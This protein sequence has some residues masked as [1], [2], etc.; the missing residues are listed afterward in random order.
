MARNSDKIQLP[1]NST[2]IATIARYLKGI[3]K[4][5][6]V[7]EKKAKEI[8]KEVKATGKRKKG[9]AADSHTTGTLRKYGLIEDV[10]KTMFS[11]SELGLELVKNYDGDGNAIVDEDD[12]ISINLKI[13]ASWYE[14][15]KGRD[16][17]P[18]MIILKLLCD[19][20][21]GFYITE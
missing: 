6:K 12:I 17:H 21:M 14:T 5:G 7:N 9:G 18:G 8:Y 16:I 13:F 15:T 1:T 10:S 20:E 11:V 19:E 2:D 3:E 4:E